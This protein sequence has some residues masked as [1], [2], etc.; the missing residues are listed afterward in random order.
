MHRQDIL[1]SAPSNKIV[2]PEGYTSISLRQAS[3][4]QDVRVHSNVF[5]GNTQPAKLGSRSAKVNQ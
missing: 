3:Y 1:G 5:L 4:I 2:T